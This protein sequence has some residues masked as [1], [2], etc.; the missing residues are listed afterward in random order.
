[1]DVE[2]TGDFQIE[3]CYFNGVRGVLNLKRYNAHRV[4]KDLSKFEKFGLLPNGD[5]EW[6]GG[7][8]IS[9]EEINKKIVL[10]N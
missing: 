6:S 5:L 8:R 3:I 10:L 9:K 2:I 7:V 4:F 1:M